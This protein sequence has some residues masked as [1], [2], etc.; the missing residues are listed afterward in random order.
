MAARGRLL[1]AKIPRELPDEYMVLVATTRTRLNSAIQR[2]AEFADG[3]AERF[4]PSVRQRLFRRIVD[5]LDLIE[6]TR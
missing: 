5:D 3:S 1:L 4:P 6:N 2:A